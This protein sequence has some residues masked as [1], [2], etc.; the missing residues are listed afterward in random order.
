MP[1]RCFET[2]P[3]HARLRHRLHRTRNVFECAVPAHLP[4]NVRLYRQPFFA[5]KLYM[6]A[7]ALGATACAP[8]LVLDGADEDRF[9]AP[10][11]PFT[12]RSPCAKLGDEHAVFIR[13]DFGAA[14]HSAMGTLLNT[15]VSRNAI[16][17]PGLQ[18]GRR[19]VTVVATDTRGY[20]I[21]QNFVLRFGSDRSAQHEVFQAKRV[22]PSRAACD[23]GSC[24]DCPG[25]PV[26]E[27][28][29]QVPAQSCDFYTNCAE[30]TL[31]CGS[32]GYP[33]RYGA[34]NCG[35]FA[36]NLDGFSP[37]GQ[38]WIWSVMTCLQWALVEPVGRCGATCQ[39]I[40][41]AAFESHPACYVNSGVC[42]LPYRDLVEIVVT[43]NSDLFAGPALKQIFKTT[44][45][46]AAHY[47]RELGAKIAELE[48]EVHS[49]P[50]RG[51]VVHAEIVL[52]RGVK[53]MIGS[54]AA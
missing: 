4:R 43:V 49:K 47:D 50:S 24:Q 6:L 21:M 9:N 48:D 22:E 52:L 28:N 35:R 5:M 14:P 29:C 37:S 45:G 19:I 53:K 54:F 23:C 13:G 36:H 31:H 41:D 16:V 26:C 1:T 32:G 27:P 42:G 46:C 18:P 17:V 12:V 20:P 30:D 40:E 39:V 7:L 38:A 8:S 15:T 44:A 51:P 11:V 3:S 25:R 33:I 2:V 34:K 10:H